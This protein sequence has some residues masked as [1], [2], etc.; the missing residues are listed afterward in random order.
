MDRAVDTTAVPVAVVALG[1]VDPAAPLG[2]GWIAPARIAVPDATDV[3]WLVVATALGAIARTIPAAP[4][5]GWFA[6]GRLVR[7]TVPGASAPAVGW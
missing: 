3:G 7:I 2:V 4:E 6:L 1:V 5:V